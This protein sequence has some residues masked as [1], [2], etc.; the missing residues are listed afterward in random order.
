MT[1]IVASLPSGRSPG[2]GR[3]RLWVGISAVGTMVTVAITALITGLPNWVD[4]QVGRGLG[5]A[6]L[7][8]ALYAL[9]HAAVQ[10]PFDLFGGYLLPTWYG[11]SGLG[12]WAFLGRITRGAVVYGI[13]LFASL[14][15]LLVGGKVGGVWGV[16][17]AGAIS[18]CLL[19]WWRFALARTLAVV[20][21]DDLEGPSTVVFAS[22]NDVGFTGG[23]LG[24]L[25]PGRIVLPSLWKTSLRPDQLSYARLRREIA[26]SS[27]AWHR[28][29]VAAMVFTLAGIG[30]SA[31]AVGPG[32]VGTAGGTVEFGL[33]FTL[34]SFVGLLTLPTL[35][36]RGVAELD[37]RVRDA[38]IPD[39]LAT[40]TARELDAH[41][42]GEPDRPAL[43][44]AIFHPIPSIRNREAMMNRPI[45]GAWDA[46]R[47]AVFLGLSAGGLLD[48]AVHCNCGRPAL[49]AFLP[50]D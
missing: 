19:L 32:R 23:V 42:D 27:G 50:V 4:A 37:A 39:A 31:V 45:L 30:L 33:W 2:Y 18:S 36:R 6:L 1:S 21:I 12:M 25:R 24:V 14:V 43:I 20:H 9:T 11:R 29:R 7:P 38:S 49:W 35:S 46:A 48:R 41:Q 34:W 10:L 17:A 28:G 22:S 40:S 44:E 16:I 47:T 26:G 8:L 15:I 5:T 13:V 3:A